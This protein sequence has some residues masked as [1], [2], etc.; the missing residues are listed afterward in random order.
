MRLK[1]FRDTQRLVPR[2]HLAV[3]VLQV[4][5]RTTGLDAGAAVGA[6]AGQM[7]RQVALAAV[8]DAQ[9]AMDKDFQFGIDSVPDGADLLQR[10]FPLQ[11][12]TAV[13][14]ALGETGLF[15]RADGALGGG[16][17]DHSLGGQPRHGR[18]LDN[19]GVHP[20]ILQSLQQTP[21]LR[22]LLLI[23]QG[24]ERHINT[25]AETVRVLA[26]PADVLHRVAGRLPGPEGRAGDIDGIGPAVDGGNADIGRT[27]RGEEFEISPLRLR[28]HSR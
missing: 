24:I 3:S 19:Q 27:G 25:N 4:I 20:G 9:G 6:A 8:A 10:E 17:K 12:E 28:L 18:V 2:E 11:D 5:E 16:V 23:D 13:T 22:N 14:Q 1:S 21:G 7:L 26:E 15:R